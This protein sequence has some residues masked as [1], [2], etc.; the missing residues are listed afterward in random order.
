MGRIDKKTRGERVRWSLFA[1]CSE[2][3]KPWKNVLEA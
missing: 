1:V 3:K 2:R